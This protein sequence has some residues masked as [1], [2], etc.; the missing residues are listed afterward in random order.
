MFEAAS[1]TNR[2]Q[3]ARMSVIGLLDSSRKQIRSQSLSR[4]SSDDRTQYLHTLGEIANMRQKVTRIIFL[5]SQDCFECDTL[6]LQI[7]SRAVELV[8]Q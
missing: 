1:G 5:W 4:V 3:Q 8:V 2:E 7:S 6:I